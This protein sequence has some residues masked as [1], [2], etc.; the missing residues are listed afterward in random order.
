VGIAIKPADEGHLYGRQGRAPAA[1][2]RGGVP[3][4]VSL[5]S[6]GSPWRGSRLIELEVEP[7]WWAPAAAFVD[8]HRRP[9]AAT[10][11]VPRRY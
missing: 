2:R 5:S 3:H 6:P 4:L 10:P 1:R 8:R 7:A 9:R 11:T